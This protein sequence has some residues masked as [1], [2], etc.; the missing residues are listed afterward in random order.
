[1]G[2]GSGLIGGGMGQLGGLAGKQ[3]VMR[4]SQDASEQTQLVI[5]SALGV[6]TG[7]AS[8]ALTTLI[9]KVVDNILKQGYITKADIAQIISTNPQLVDD[10][11][12]W[13]LANNYIELLSNEKQEEKKEAPKANV[14]E[15]C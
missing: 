7:S 13:L 14:T 10:L 8:S 5:R 3:I 9:V 12:I 4:L 1:M 2:A 6:A 15:K 11:W